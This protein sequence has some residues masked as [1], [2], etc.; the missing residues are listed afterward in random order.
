MRW[1]IR[2]AAD[3]WENYGEAPPVELFFGSSARGG[4]CMTDK[5]DYES[6]DPEDWNQMRAL[7]HRMVDDAITYLETVRERPVWRPV[8]DDVAARF[9]APAPD[10][11][12]G[13]GAVYQEFLEN[14]FPY[15]M[16]NI[17]PRFWAWYMG[18]GTVFGAL[19]DF[20]AAIMNPNLGGGNHV[21]NLVEGQVVNWMKAMLGF[22][23][24]SSGLL[25]SGG[26]MA[27]F[28]GIAVAR[29]THAGFNVRELGLK[30]APQP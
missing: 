28:I 22:P 8:P 14:I 1:R 29:N 25:V 2:R 9:D 10:K 17:H 19:P 7:A 16:G 13:A 4:N 20:M 23:P 3:G 30:A 27:N 24:D 5:I 26:S 12:A 18:N 11:P 21:A 6:L 15:P